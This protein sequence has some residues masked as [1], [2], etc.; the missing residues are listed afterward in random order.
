M[1]ISDAVALL[2]QV[3]VAIGGLAGLTSVLLVSSQ[4]RKLVAESGKT[5]AEADVAF[6]EAY[7]QRATTQVTL[8]EPYERIQARMQSE[9]DEQAEKIDRLEIY[10]EVLVD[11]LRQQGVSVPPKPPRRRENNG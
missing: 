2:V 8:I 9:I 10:I 1:N 3:I 4:K 5:N 7:R 11:L 6:S